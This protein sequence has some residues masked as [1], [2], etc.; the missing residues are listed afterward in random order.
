M[1]I[2]WNLHETLWKLHV[3]SMETRWIL[4]GTSW[5]FHGTFKETR[6]KLHETSTIHLF[7][8]MKTPWNL[9]GNSMERSMKLT[10]MLVQHTTTTQDHPKLLTQSPRPMAVQNIY[11]TR[12]NLPSEA[13]SPSQVRVLGPKPKIQYVS[14]PRA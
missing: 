2:E 3:S 10:V 1:E 11:T 5:K 13:Y 9:H 4:H 14:F 8:F 6:W 12:T 7:N